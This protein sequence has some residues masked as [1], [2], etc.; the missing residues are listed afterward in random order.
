MRSIINF[1]QFPS[2]RRNSSARALLLGSLGLVACSS[3]FERPEDRGVSPARSTQALSIDAQNPANSS[4]AD[5]YS[6]QVAD[7]AQVGSLTPDQS[8]GMPTSFGPVVQRGSINTQRSLLAFDLSALPAD[9]IIT[10]ATLSLTTID[11]SETLTLIQRATSDWTGDS[12][13]WTTQPTT[14]ADSVFVPLASDQDP[15]HVI[16][17]TAL[18]AAMAKPGQNHGLVLRLADETSDAHWSVA[19]G[20]ALDAAQRPSLTLEFALPGQSSGVTGVPANSMPT[21]GDPASSDPNARAAFYT[22]TTIGTTPPAPVTL[23]GPPCHPKLH[24]RAQPFSNG[25]EPD[26]FVIVVRNGDKE[27]AHRDIEANNCYEVLGSTQ[28]QP[29]DEVFDVTGFGSGEYSVSVKLQKKY[30]LWEVTVNED[31]ITPSVYID[32]SHCSTGT[33]T[34]VNNTPPQPLL[35]HIAVDADY[36]GD[37]ITDR[38]IFD[39]NNGR[40]YVIASSGNSPIPWGWQWAGTARNFLP[41][42]ADYDGDGKADRALVNPATGQWY[43]I[44]TSGGSPVPWGWKWAGMDAHYRPIVADYDGDGRADRAILDPNTSQ[45]Y[46]VPSSGSSPIPWGWKW[47]GMDSHYRPIVADYDGDGKADR[48]ILDPNTSQWYVI[49]SSGNAPFPWGWQWSGMDAHHRVLVADYDGDGKADRAIADPNT[50]RWYVIA[51]SGNS[52][53]PWGWQWTGMGPQHRIFIGDFDGDHKADRAL[54]DP[55][56][57]RWYIITSSGKSV[58]P[59]GTKWTG[60]NLAPPT[61]TA[62]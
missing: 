30:L 11:T 2:F 33:T 3:G 28:C 4:S 36:D 1:V 7:E 58:L 32:V 25:Y 57:Q 19:S 53:I 13:T 54:V 45:W 14:A 39:P 10:K 5:D 49:A 50:G 16:D 38:A 37:G 20:R 22:G 9:A 34:T 6:L 43:V 27:V 59:W 12:A 60:L 31:G 56:D 17:V 48:A 40:W 8:L 51:S 15:Q 62:P 42:V 52:P 29:L 35:F 55:A 47:G 24:V 23:E 46:V 26:R 44:A 41:V 18:V 61:A 21:S